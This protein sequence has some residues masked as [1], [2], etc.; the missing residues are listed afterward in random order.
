MRDLVWDWR[1]WNKV[2]RVAAALLLSLVVVL[3]AIVILS[4]A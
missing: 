3:P 2:E 1:H 4:A